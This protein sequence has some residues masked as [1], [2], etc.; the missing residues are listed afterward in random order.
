MVI[1]GA[2]PIG[3][4]LFARSEAQ[5]QAQGQNQ[6]ESRTIWSGVFSEFQARR[7]EKVASISCGGCHGPDLDG[8]DSGPRLVGGSFLSN[9]ADKSIWDLFDWISKSMPADSPGSLSREN[10]ANLIA[11]ILEL[12]KA[13]AGPKDLPIDQAGLSQI[14]IVEPQTL[15]K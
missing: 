14:R 3:I 6:S 15:Q 13:D 2:V 11:Y 9:W 12:N 10:T 5:L 1:F 4:A 7:G 8:G